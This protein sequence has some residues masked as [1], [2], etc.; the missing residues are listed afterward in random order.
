[1]MTLRDAESDRIAGAAA[2]SGAS[3]AVMADVQGIR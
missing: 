3:D 1:M 2:V